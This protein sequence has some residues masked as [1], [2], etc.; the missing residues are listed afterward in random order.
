VVRT[1][2]ALATDGR[3][4]L[5]MGAFSAGLWPVPR[6]KAV[7]I[8]CPVPGIFTLV[9]DACFAGF[10]YHSLRLTEDYSMRIMLTHDSN[11]SPSPIE[12]AFARGLGV[13][14]ASL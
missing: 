3:F 10:R 11:P 4:A 8:P 1:Q 9:Y 5:N 2:R 7:G 14:E 6:V 12:E 13:V